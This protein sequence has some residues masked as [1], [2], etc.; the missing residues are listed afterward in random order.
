M[1]KIVHS[2]AV[3][4]EDLNVIPESSKKLLTIKKC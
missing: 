3:S 1:R 4:Y 2:S